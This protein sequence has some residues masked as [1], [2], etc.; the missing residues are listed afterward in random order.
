MKTEL[1]KHNSRVLYSIQLAGRK[2]DT[3]WLRDSCG[4]NN[5]NNTKMLL[6]CFLQGF[7]VIDVHF[8]GELIGLIPLENNEWERFF[9]YH[10]HYYIFS[11]LSHLLFVLIV[12]GSCCV[13]GHLALCAA[14]GPQF[15]KFPQE[16]HHV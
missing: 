7:I 6:N 14:S 16:L 5:N 15:Y 2:Q 9:W 4:N 13:T 8:F 11:V 12:F 3:F 1:F 10:I